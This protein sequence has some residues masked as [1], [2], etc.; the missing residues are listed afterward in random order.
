[1]LSGV[2]CEEFDRWFDGSCVIDAQGLPLVLY[3]GTQYV[4][5]RFDPDMQGD[6]VWSE[7]VGFFFTNNPVEA[8]SYAIFDWDRE[9]P[10]P[11]VL[12]VY[13]AMRNP[14]VICITDEQRPGETGATWY[15]VYGREAAAQALAAG[16]DGLIIGD[17]SDDPMLTRSGIRETLF[18]AFSPD[19]VA[20]AIGLYGRPGVLGPAAHFHPPAAILEVGRSAAAAPRERRCALVL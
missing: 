4:F 20:S 6:T 15:D 3:H 9:D 5:D 17:F 11:N 8:D 7:D 1:M 18:V 2:G 13:L 10:A 14:L 16:H 12:P 19:Q